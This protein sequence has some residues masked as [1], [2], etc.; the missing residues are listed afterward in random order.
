MS[1]AC[2]KLLASA[3]ISSPLRIANRFLPGAISIPTKSEWDSRFPILTRFLYAN[4]PPL[5]LKTLCWLQSLA[6][7]TVD[8]VK[9]LAA[10]SSND[11]IH[12][13]LVGFSVCFESIL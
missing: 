1:G 2:P 13:R 5:R 10:A 9:D 3:S 8:D 6:G 12:V 4:R 7:D 11:G